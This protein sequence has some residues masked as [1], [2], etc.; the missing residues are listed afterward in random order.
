[1]DRLQPHDCRPFSVADQA[2]QVFRNAIHG[3]RKRVPDME[4]AFPVK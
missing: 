1:V 4:S 2:L 3:V